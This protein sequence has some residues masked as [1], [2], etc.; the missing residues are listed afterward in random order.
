MSH[1]AS[2]RCPLASRHA[3][4]G[5]ARSSLGASSS[6]AA[7]AA[8]A[9]PRPLAAGVSSR[10]Q[11]T[12]RPPVSRS[13]APTRCVSTP[14]R[15]AKDPRARVALDPSVVAVRE[16]TTSGE[17]RA[18]AAARALTFYEYPPDRSEYSVRA[19]RNMRIDAEW[20]AIGEKIAGTDVAFKNCRVSCLVA[21]LPL[22]EDGAAPEGFG[23]D[24]GVHPA[25]VL[26]TGP[27]TTA[28]AW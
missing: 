8:A 22:L 18:S 26:Y 10:R 21:A 4:L 6:A 17:L 2:T 11:Q 9:S 7:A 15:S 12:P 27:H 3:L 14:E 24:D 20:D 19:H 23:I 13:R 5:R 28:L 16:T 25:C 1:A